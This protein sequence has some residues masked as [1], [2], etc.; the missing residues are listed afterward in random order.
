[1]LITCAMPSLSSLFSFLVLTL[2][3]L[4]HASSP[5]GLWE[6][7]FASCRLLHWE[8]HSDVWDDDCASRVSSKLSAQRLFMDTYSRKAAESIT[9]STLN[10]LFTQ[11]QLGNN[12]V[13]LP[14]IFPRSFMMVG[15]PFGTKTSVIQVLADTLTL[16]NE[17]GLNEEDKVS[18]HILLQK[19]IS[20]QR[21]NVF[22]LSIWVRLIF[23]FQNNLELDCSFR[24]RQK[25][26]DTNSLWKII[27]SLCSLR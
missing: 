17:R 12:S 5:I 6:A 4:F 24:W 11:W 2:F 23:S 27:A 7:Q 16:L 3:K 13:F 10:I 14:V 1:M 25:A 20:E 18:Q 21:N 26:H 8:T 15:D 9:L 19:N 22:L